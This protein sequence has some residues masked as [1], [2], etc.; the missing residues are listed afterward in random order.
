MTALARI[1]IDFCRLSPGQEKNQ[2]R[3]SVPSTSKIS[4]RNSQLFLHTLDIDELL[5]EF[6]IIPTWWVKSVF[7]RRI[8]LHPSSES[9]MQRRTCRAAENASV[10]CRLSS[11]RLQEFHPKRYG[12][13]VSWG[14]LLQRKMFFSI[15]MEPGPWATV[16]VM[17]GGN[18]TN[19][20][21][22]LAQRD[23]TVASSQSRPEG[24]SRSCWAASKRP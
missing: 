11:C 5:G 16:N 15:P 6:P 21:S 3:L 9:K 10:V 20:G 18:V 1:R 17:L 22:P 24:M 7:G 8:Q 23:P 4:S 2:Q 12:N 13:V 14:P 19:N